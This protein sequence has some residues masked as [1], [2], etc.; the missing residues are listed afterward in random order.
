[1]NRI[2]F[3]WLL[4]I[5]ISSQAAT[6]IVTNTN[7]SGAGSLRDAIANAVN[8]DVI[9][10]DPNLLAGSP[11]I[12]LQSEI[13]FSKSLNINGL[14]S[15]TDTLRISGNNI[16][17]IFNISNTTS[18]VLDSLVLI[19]GYAA[20]STGKGG[21]V[22]FS[23]S[24][25]LGITN[26]LF[27]NNTSVSSGGGVYCKANQLSINSCVFYNN[28]SIGGGGG[29]GFYCHN[30]LNCWNSKFINNTSNGGSGVSIGPNN[31]GNICY[32]NFY[33]CAIKKNTSNFSGG[34][35]SASINGQLELVFSGCQIDSN[36]ANSQGGGIY[37]NV[38]AGVSTSCLIV[39]NAT[40]VSYNVST[41]NNGGGIYASA[42]GFSLFSS[43]STINMTGS[44]VNNNTCFASGSKGG[45]IFN[46][47]NGQRILDCKR[48]T[49]SNNNA[50]FGGGVYEGDNTAPSLAYITN[51]TIYENNALLGSS[52]YAV[53]ST[54][55]SSIISAASNNIYSDVNSPIT[56]NGYNIF[57][58]A[59][60]GTIGTDQIN[61]T[62]SQLNLLPLLGITKFHLPLS[63]SQAID[64]GNPSDLTNAQ[65]GSILNGR[66]D[67]GAAESCA[68][69]TIDYHNL[70]QPSFTWT[71]GDGNTY[72]ND[73][74]V[75]YLLPVTNSMG[76]DSF[77][78]LSLNSVI[79]STDTIVSCS[80]II[81][82]DGITYNT[83]NYS[84]THLLTSAAG[85]D[86]IVTLN[87]TING[88]I[89]SYS[90]IDNGN[91]NYSFTNNS[92]GNYNQSHWAFGDG[93]TSILTNLNHTF[94]SNGSF[95]VVLTINDSITSCFDY[96]LDTILVT[97]IIS[98]LQ[99]N[100][101][102]VM[103]PDTVAG[104]IIVVNSSTGTNLTYLWDFGDGDTSTLQNP[105]HI[106][107]TSG[108]F[109]LCLTVYDGGSCIDMYC[110][111]IGEN[112]VVFKAS[113]FTINVI[114]PPIITGID[115]NI[116][117]NSDVDIFPNPTSHQLSIVSNQIKISKIT[118]IDITGKTIKTIEQN[119][120][121]VNVSY[122]SKGIYF[123]KF[124]TEEQII[125]KKFVK[126]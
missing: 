92:T 101:G 16:C 110:D 36:I 84:A 8:G 95:I 93:T 94:T 82:I 116:E 123:I 72:T 51:S 7:D 38:S 9:R 58:D 78:I 39:L 126:Q 61:I 49:I 115:N 6:I 69:G 103:Y 43:A 18:V 68:S 71:A 41:N 102:F 48:S 21:A 20:D 5:S 25:S 4:L 86:S 64:M 52:I 28:T 11:T 120:N 67:V 90:H 81:W 121:L 22:H 65:N 24:S 63:P 105:T 57:S 54:I 89:A 14:Y 122:L 17:R 35:V 40:S 66:R 29:G 34:G 1:M 83:S 46:D 85:C 60:N 15:T 99:C 79:Y 104:N 80:P 32:V 59:P 13:A 117:L 88:S 26:S 56:S 75:Y 27:K 106:Y 23:Y 109:Y 62:P 97:G 47:S 114:S 42:Y 113:G 50:D 108:P 107:S 111:S 12:T 70:C 45:G 30:N 118:I 53:N 91:G 2:F 124:F 10:F 125:T 55:E 73:T 87:L 98:P 44:S 31:S 100:S 112:G 77:L 19:N 96:F 76:C 37:A 74:T 119:T 33:S 3:I